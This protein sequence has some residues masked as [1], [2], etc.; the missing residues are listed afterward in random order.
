M[1][2]AQDQTIAPRP[3]GRFPSTLRR[4]PPWWPLALC[5]LL[6]TLAG[7]GY[8]V[9][10]SPLYSATSYV[11]V[12]PTRPGD[13]ATALGF[14]HAYGR[15]VTNSAVLADAQAA[16][17]VPE[18]DLKSHVA[19]VTSPDAPMIEITG[20]DSRPDQSATI[21]NEV[22]RALAAYANASA[23][24][25]DVRL[26]VL[27][28]APVPNSPTSPSGGIT[29]AVGACAGLLLGC[30]IM[31]VR[32][33]GRREEESRAAGSRP[34]PATATGTPV[35][36]AAP[37]PAEQDQPAAQHQPPAQ[38]KPAPQDQPAPPVRTPAPKTSAVNK[39][40]AKPAS[41]KPA[42]A[43][44]AS[45]RSASAKPASARPVSAAGKSPAHATVTAQAAEPAS[46]GAR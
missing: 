4:L 20:S 14:A 29:T 43:K 19:A 23:R 34:G 7:A 28:K 39:P 35:I 41:A 45:A 12:A 8:G 1:T 11:V 36:P 46:K 15:V 22:A 9:L 17:G 6:G 37:K 40:P 30:L 33:G 38:P 42:S 3:A 13:P 27:S 5:I 24:S 10:K 26:N 32:P 2:D 25:T 21:A 44:P 31:L 16:T 18:A